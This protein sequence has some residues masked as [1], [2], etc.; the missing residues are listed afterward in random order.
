MKSLSGYA[1]QWGS[2]NSA[3]VEAPLKGVVGSWYAAPEST[4]YVI[5]PL[6][7]GSSYSVR[8]AAYNAIGS[9]DFVLATLAKQWAEVQVISVQAA[10]SLKSVKYSL[11]W[12]DGFRNESTGVL[13]ADSAAASV[14]S[15]LQSLQSIS[16][17]LVT[18]ID[19]SRQYDSTSTAVLG[20]TSLE[21]RVTFVRSQFRANKSSLVIVCASGSV[22]NSAP[23]ISISVST[24]VSGTSETS[25]IV[26]M[27]TTISSAPQNV[28]MTSVSSTEIG[29]MWD[30]PVHAGGSPISKFQIQWDSS[31]FFIRSNSSENSEIVSFASAKNNNNMA[32]FSFQITGL[33]SFD[34][35]P[36]FVR[37]SAINGVGTSSAVAAR[38]ITDKA[39][40]TQCNTMPAHCSL[41][42]TSQLLHTVVDPYVALNSLQVANRLDVSWSQPAFDSNGFKTDTVGL[43]RTSSPA[44]SYRFEWANNSDFR[45]ASLVDIPMIRDDNIPVDCVMTGS[46][47]NKCTYTIGQSIQNISIYNSNVSPISSGKFA[48]MYVGKFS[49]HVMVIVKA[50]ERELEVIDGSAN[51]LVPSIGDFFRIDGVVYQITAVGG[52]L[53]S[54]VT[55]HQPFQGLYSDIVVAYYATLPTTCLDYSTVSAAGVDAYLENIF[56]DMYPAY[57][58][59]LGDRLTVV[60]IPLATGK[61]WLVSFIGESFSSDVEDLIVLDSTGQKNIHSLVTYSLVA[62]ACASGVS[63]VTT[64]GPTQTAVASV[65]H[66]AKA[67]ALTP[68]EPVYV[69]VS[70]INDIGVGPSKACSVS[71]D[72]DS[73]LGSITPRSRPGLAEKVRVYAVPS[74][75][76]NSFYVTWSE[77][78]TY[79]DPITSYIIEWS[80][81]GGHT[82]PATNTYTVPIASSALTRYNVPDTTAKGTGST[83]SGRSFNVTIIVDAPYTDHVVRVRAVNDQGSS[84]PSWFS[85]VDTN[86]PLLVNRGTKLPGFYNTGTGSHNL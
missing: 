53:S 49:R 43:G 12:S 18:R 57:T 82:F 38:P 47:G 35:V 30:A 6:S 54:K 41:L 73:S 63:Y 79:G 71:A 34:P 62:P 16:A 52:F 21:Y 51:P 83:G 78:E 42:P 10:A 50:N 7:A 25:T 27:K 37:V 67:S 61:S 75:T 11:K 5:T 20:A 23:T 3:K 26:S 32:N 40:T 39:S 65:S 45:N 22:C 13:D 84:G 85:K 68:G 60:A 9:G 15:A 4:S 74:S 86:D 19:K 28:V 69:R 29:I 55:L 31:M 56:D 17:V 80:T 44:K 1:I 66:L 72:G 59:S 76:G 64:A 70:P 36:I 46:A 14:Q 58:S 2:F 48:L 33:S 77:G 81:D 24:L 8:V